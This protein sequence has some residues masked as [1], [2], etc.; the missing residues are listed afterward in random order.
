[1]AFLHCAIPISFVQDDANNDCAH[2]GI[3]HVEQYLVIQAVRLLI[4]DEAR[5][6]VREHPGEPGE[7]AVRGQIV[8]SFD[9][10]ADLRQVE[11]DTQRIEQDEA[12]CKK[13]TEH[14]KKRIKGAEITA[15]FELLPT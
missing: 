10:L 8:A 13:T 5:G 6:E 2:E 4:E 15:S 9:E 12:T 14:V 7:E 1:M 3:R 11:Q